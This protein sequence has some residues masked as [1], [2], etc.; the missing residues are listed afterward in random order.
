MRFRG[1]A[2]TLWCSVLA[3]VWLQGCAEGFVI[4]E[5]PDSGG[6]PIGEVAYV[7]QYEWEDVPA[8]H[9][10]A[11]VSGVLFAIQGDGQISAW[12]SDSAEGREN[13]SRT[14]P[15]PVVH[16]AQAYEQPV[17]LC[18]GPS[19]TLWVA[20]EEPPS[21]L[22][23]TLSVS[24]PEPTGLLVR[25]AA[26]AV[27]GGITADLDSGYVYVADAVAN[28]VSKFEPNDVGGQLLIDVATEGN[29]DGFVREPHGIFWFDDQ[30]LVADTG[31]SWLQL[32]D[33]DVPQAGRGQISGPEQDPLQLRDPVDVW[34]DA[35]GYFYVTDTS[36]NRVLQVEEDGQVREEV[37]QLDPLSAIAPISVVANRTQVWVPN[38]AENRLT[39]YQ[40]N[41]ANEGAP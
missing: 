32:L 26:Q 1:S 14:L 7:V 11:L 28:T 8:F 17:H 23:F 4:P 9:D 34:V 10:L 33:A 3:A 6:I 12:F 18:A 2:A 39:V 35:A 21:L 29:G 20:F 41:T 40:I 27:I 31:K 30:L 36:N 13:T 16:A 15:F 22:Q 24:P 37:T 19:N 25:L 38:A 5:E